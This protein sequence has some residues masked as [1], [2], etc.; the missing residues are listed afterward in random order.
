MSFKLPRP[1]SPPT[2]TSLSDEA[3]ASLLFKSLQRAMASGEL[4]GPD[5]KIR[6]LTPTQELLGRLGTPW[7]AA[8]TVLVTGSKGKGSTAIIAA[9]ALEALG[10]RVGLITSPSLVNFR[11]RIR[12]NGRSIPSEE[13][14]RLVELIAPHVEE[15]D[16]ALPPGRYFSPTG[17]ILAIAQLHFAASGVEIAVVEA[18]RGGRFDDTRLVPNTVSILTPIMREHTEE[19]GPTLND[20]AWHKTGIIK[21][22]GVVVSTRQEPEALEVVTREA[23]LQRASLRLLGRDFET[24]FVRSGNLDRIGLEM[25][26]RTAAHDYGELWLPLLG[27][28]QVENTAVAISAV[29]ALLESLDRQPDGHALVGAVRIGLAQVTWPGRCQVLGRAPL[30]FLDGAIND[31]SAE[32]FRESVADLVRAPVVALVAVPSTKDYEGVLRQIGRIASAVV[33]TRFETPYLT[34][35]EDK[36]ALRAA[37]AHFSTAVVRPEFED[38]YEEALRLAGEQGTL[39]IV[40]TQ[41]LLKTALRHL[42]FNLEVI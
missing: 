9:K 11:E 10:Y 3:A 17:M 8:G 12:V 31:E 37:Q 40:G 34:F 32:L 23:T 26:L 39:L 35:P 27:R 20:I 42:D 1:S 6:D 25:T 2:D 18:G 5:A 15:I 22:E 21:P 14:I 4:H 33:V 30:T 24:T 7:V 19:L 36:D 16:A 28:Y 29:E 13:W 38:A 41:T